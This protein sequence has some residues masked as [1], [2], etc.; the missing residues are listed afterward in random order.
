M[1]LMREVG[2]LLDLLHARPE[3]ELA[4]LYASLEERADVVRI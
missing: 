2:N 1:P 4:R 3:E